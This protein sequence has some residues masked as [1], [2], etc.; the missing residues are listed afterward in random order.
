MCLPYLY[1]AHF[2]F[3][4]WGAIFGHAARGYNTP[5]DRDLE[6]DSIEV[7]LKHV[8]AA[9]SPTPPGGNRSVGSDGFARRLRASRPEDHRL[10]GRSG[11]GS[12]RWRRGRERRGS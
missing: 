4:Y 11:C 2:A 12:G 5:I 7:V 8:W 10:Q 9:N 1:S 6:A 3:L